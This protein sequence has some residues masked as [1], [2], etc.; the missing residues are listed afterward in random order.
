LKSVG[1]SHHLGS[2]IQ[3][4]F[5]L[6]K[7]HHPKLCNHN[8]NIKDRL[9]KTPQNNNI[10]RCLKTKPK[11]ED[12]EDEG[13]QLNNLLIRLQDNYTTLVLD[14]YEITKKIMNSDYHHIRCDLEDE[15]EFLDNEMK[16]VSKKIKK[17]KLYLEYKVSCCCCCCC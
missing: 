15:A 11:I 4:V 14:H 3:N 13:D 8:S 12:E 1:V 5:S 10:K 17:L 7:Q 2:N 9:T 16:I 6:L